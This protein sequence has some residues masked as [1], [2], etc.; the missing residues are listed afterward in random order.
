MKKFLLGI[1]VGFV[2]T[3]LTAVIVFFVMVRLGRR[4]PQ[5]PDPAVLVLRVEGEIPETPPM[6]I[7]LPFLERARPVNMKEY[8]DILRKAASDKRIRAVVLMPHDLR[9][10]WAKVQQLRESLERYRKSGKPLYAFLRAPGAREYYL[11]AAA[12]R[13]YISPEDYLD[14]KGLRVELMY[15]KNT[16]DKVGVEVEVAS[17]GK[18][19]DAPDM[20][21]RTSMS[22]ETREVMNSILDEVYGN[23][24]QTV[25]ASRK[26]TPEQ[27]RATVDQG[28]FT[29]PQALAKGLVDG[30]LYEDQVF[31]EIERR[32]KAGELRKVPVRDY[33]RVPAES[34]GLEGG[35]RIALVV[36]EGVIVRGGDSGPFG[37][38]NLIRSEE[39]VKLLRQVGSDRRIRGVVVRIDSPG[40]DG[41][42]SDEIWREMNL[43]SDKKPVVISM[44]DS[45]ASGGYYIAM[46]GD[47][48]VAYPGTVTGSIGVFYGKAN[49]RE[50]YNKLGIQKDILTR[51]RFAAIDSDY[52]PLSRDGREKLE[53]AVDE[54]YKSFVSR[55][56]RSRK[57]NYAEIEPLAQG[58]VW[59]GS[60]AKRNG[61]VD[62][63]GGLDRAIELVKEK[64]GIPASES[65]RLITYPPKRTI[66]D[67]LFG[68]SQQLLDFRLAAFF[69]RGVTKIWPRDGIYRLMPFVIEV[70]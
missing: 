39:F 64:A 8:W 57:R 60:Q 42:A 65:V 27:V 10:G 53:A 18:Y 6:E 38:E 29:S 25:A 54:F 17:A 20:F 40:G 2:L 4:P 1:L 56:A 44:S 62:Q 58:R 26:Q 31:G 55:V 50:L 37:G 13:I 69:R 24:I 11:G 63:L 35:R 70:K 5:I 28:P 15:L 23:L 51:G 7:P 21:T 36:A 48:I 67:W 16:L 49:L 32:V 9:A 59:L 43:L 34:L 14:L 68:E 47:P 30:L 33:R 45:A 52:V 22:P 46:T 19:K 12:E 3:A 66:F 41:F 61:L